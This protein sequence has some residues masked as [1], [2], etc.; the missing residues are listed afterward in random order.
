VGSCSDLYTV[1]LFCLY[2][3][4]ILVCNFACDL[5]CFIVNVY[6]VKSSVELMLYCSVWYI[7]VI[8]PYLCWSSYS[9]AFFELR[10][11]IAPNFIFKILSSIY[12]IL[13]VC[14]SYEGWSTLPKGGF[15]V[16]RF[17]GKYCM[18]YINTNDG[19][20]CQF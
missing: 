4:A 2:F 17:V 16:H 13:L 14:I 3:L 19:T 8:V 11:L 7:F 20:W 6:S 18:F 9:L 12:D 1:L 10:L 15:L 5:C